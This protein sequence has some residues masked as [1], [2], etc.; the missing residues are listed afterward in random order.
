MAK[1][2]GEYIPQ[3]LSCGFVDPMRQQRGYF[4][5]EYI[6]DAIDGEAWLTQHGA[7]PLTTAL[8]V[9]LQIAKGLQLAHQNG[10]YHLD[11][12]PA[13]LLLQA[14]S[15]ESS[16]PSEPSE[17]PKVKIIDFGLAKIA[18]SV[19]DDILAQRS[20]SGLSRMAQSTIFGTLDYAP[21][22]QQGI[23]GVGEP[24][25]KSD[26]YAFGKTLYRPVSH[27]SPQTLRPKYFKGQMAV[28]ELL[29]DCVEINPQQRPDIVQLIHTLSDLLAA[30]KVVT[31][32]AKPSLIH[33][34]SNLL[35][36]K[37]AVTASAKASP[38]F[39]EP[40][41]VTVPAGE[42][43]MG[44]LEER[45]DVEGGCYGDE[46]PAHKVM[47]E[48]FLLA[49]YPVTLKAFRV[50]IQATHYQTTAEQKGSAYGLVDGKW[51]NHKGL[52]WQQVGFE[53]SETHPVVCI[54]WH[55][56]QAYIQWLNQRSG[57]TYRLP[58]EAEWEYAA[59]A[60]TDT[61]YPWGNQPSHHHA[62]YDG[63]I[64]KTTAV[65]AYP[66]NDFG[67][68]DLQGNVW[69]W[70]QDKWHDNYNKAPTNGDAWE[71]GAIRVLRGGSWD[72]TPG[73]L[74]S[75]DRYWITPDDRNYGIGFRLARSPEKSSR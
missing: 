30:K 66:A 51:D 15:P 74:R 11:L 58:S 34:L 63:K 27:E 31:A 70:G 33:T 12:K 29:C 20:R 55:D 4:V 1:I 41:M 46:K 73:N 2:A 65:D 8:A 32:S 3:P 43:I 49:K 71:S 57:Q 69:E 59:R 23:Q 6:K 67:L 53:Q 42:F 25:A 21:P 17:P 40:E 54:S 48:S 64:G 19:G 36:A 52:H 50:F 44:C 47:L 56:T 26:I 16:E 22:E 39:I 72:L 45:D 9:G 37:K 38:V 7:M 10:I 75:A 18:P 62:N 14:Q 28:Y 60:N 68:H 35:A 61:A 24:S 5:A 13:N